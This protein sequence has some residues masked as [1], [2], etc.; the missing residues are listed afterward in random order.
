VC[1]SETSVAEGIELYNHTDFGQDFDLS[2]PTQNLAHM[3]N[4]RLLQGRLR[5][6]L[7]KQ[8]QWN[9]VPVGGRGHEH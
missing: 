1:R 6:V 2:T 3:P 7:L 5:A 8:F 9:H 4:L